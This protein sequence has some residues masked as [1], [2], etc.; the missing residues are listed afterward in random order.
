MPSAVLPRLSRVPFTQ[1][2]KP[3]CGLYLGSLA[4]QVRRGMDRRVVLVQFALQLRRERKEKGPAAL[5]VL[6]EFL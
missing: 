5:A 2:G 3:F 1:G 6:D 4:V